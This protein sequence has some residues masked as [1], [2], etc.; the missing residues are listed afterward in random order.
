M[1]YLIPQA[2]I[3]AAEKNPDHLALRYNGQSLTYSQLVDKA[4]RLARTLQEHGISR[5]DRVG[6][7]LNKSFEIHHWPL[8]DY[9][10]WGRIYPP[11][12]IRPDLA[13]GICDPGL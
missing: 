2:I 10:G 6:I 11:R 7:Y 4:S 1:I 12:P 13:A 3:A 8:W 9:D 5:G